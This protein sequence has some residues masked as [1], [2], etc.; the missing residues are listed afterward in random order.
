MGEVIHAFGS[1]PTKA[2]T[3]KAA[4]TKASKVPEVTLG[5][6][7]TNIAAT[8]L[9][10][11]WG[12]AVSAAL[13][14]GFFSATLILGAVFAAAVT[15]QVRAQRFLP[16]WYWLAFAATTTVATTLADVADRSLGIG[17]TGGL[18]LLASLFG[19]SLW[20]WR[21]ALGSLSIYRIDTA[22]SERFYWTAIVLAQTLGMALSDWTMEVPGLDREA[23]MMM[24]AA[25]LAAMAVVYFR[26]SM[27][28]TLLFW[29][30]FVAT[31][32][33]GAVVGG[34]LDHS[35]QAGGMALSR[36]TT[37]MALA[38]V[39]LLCIVLFRQRAADK[40]L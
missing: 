3:N 1:E 33:L 16:V 19:A 13:D 39:V 6:W 17:F 23:S 37:M 12:D 10:E 21:R 8:A 32:P 38:G 31:R 29:L 9:G 5:F 22:R 27:S 40:S 36:G 7:L 11:T 35:A 20:A 2:A 25:L 26:T 4:T 30:A 34:L 15:A 14:F 28:R 18:L 24:F